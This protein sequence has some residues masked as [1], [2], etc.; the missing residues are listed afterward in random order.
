MAEDFLHHG[1]EDHVEFVQWYGGAG[2]LGE[3]RLPILAQFPW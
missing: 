2:N 1:A 3:S